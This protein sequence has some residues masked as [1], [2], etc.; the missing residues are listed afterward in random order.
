MRS[1]STL[2]PENSHIRSLVAVLISAVS[3][4]ERGP[5]TPVEQLNKRGLIIDPCS[6]GFIGRD[7]SDVIRG[8]EYIR[9]TAT[10]GVY[11]RT[12]M[13]PQQFPVRM[14]DLLEEILSVQLAERVSNCLQ[15]KTPPIALTEIYS[16]AERMRKTLT[17]DSAHSYGPT[18][19]N[20]IVPA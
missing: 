4:L 14:S 18:L 15:G 10:T 17:L 5:S 12:A 9:I 13:R 7:E 3:L 2:S 20:A 16:I 6:S 1:V 11:V 19:N 8:I